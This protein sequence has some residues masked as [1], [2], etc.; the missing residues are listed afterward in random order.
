VASF[1][2]NVQLASPEKE[3][4]ADSSLLEDEFCRDLILNA[5]RP[6]GGGEGGTEDKAVT[7]DARKMTQQ[8]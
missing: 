3:R 4:V 8:Q 6:P 7:G 2:A 1:I 5:D